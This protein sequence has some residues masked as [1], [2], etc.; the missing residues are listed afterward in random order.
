MTVRI[1]QDLILIEPLGMALQA[2]RRITARYDAAY[3]DRCGSYEGTTVGDAVNQAR[4]ALVARHYRGL[5]VDVGVGAGTFVRCRPNTLGWDVN[6]AAAAWLGQHGW[7]A[8]KL[9]GWP[10]YSMWDVIE[11]L[12]NPDDTLAAIAPEAFLFVS[13]PVFDR[14]AD[15]RGSRHYRPGEHLQYWTHDGFL[16]W[17]QA[18]QFVLL[19]DNAAET[20]AGRESIRSYAFQRVRS[21]H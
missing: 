16:R 1:E 19:E 15:I 18:R 7:W 11:H 8:S 3:A 6:P 12:P 20:E 4:I 13:L 14:L 9:D 2:D 17:M 10:A 5:L 21:G